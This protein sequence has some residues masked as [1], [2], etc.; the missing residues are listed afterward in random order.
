MSKSQN[1]YD[2]QEFFDGYRKLRENPY[3]ANNVEEKPALFSLSP[4]LHGKAV[5]DL[6]CGYGENCAMFRELGAAVVTGVDL[7]EKML[8]IAG[9]EHP[10]IEFL[11]GDMS[12]LS[13][14]RRKY[15]VIF[16]SLALHYIEDFDA[17]VK[18]VYNLLTPGGIFV[19]SQ[20]HPLSTAP[21]GGSSWTKDAD[22]NVL[23][24]NLSDYTRCGKR[25]TRWFVDG[26]EKYHRTFSEIVNALVG[27]GFSIE[28][29]L[30]PIPDE[31]T[32]RRDSRWE[33]YFHKPNFLLIKAMKRK[34][35]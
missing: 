9:A 18:D 1:I 25:T 17:L 12:D 23:H 2:N 10:D 15:D 14:I 8:A 20:E 28:K 31:E 27:A 3:S 30:E 5:L 13:F 24:Y 7:S 6:G 35:E 26:V 33:R 11:R 32:V 21:I 34:E 22:G 19:F 29:M 4:D 16:S